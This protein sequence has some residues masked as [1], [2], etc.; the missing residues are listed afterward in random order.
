MDEDMALGNQIWVLGLTVTLLLMTGGVE[1]N[2]EPK[3]DQKKIDQIIIY[4]RKQEEEIKVS[5]ARRGQ[6]NNKRRK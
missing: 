3:A 4:L 2:P 1:T 5:K 6:A